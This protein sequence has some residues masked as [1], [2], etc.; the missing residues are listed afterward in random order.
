[1]TE[2]SFQ[3]S[4][5]GNAAPLP[6]TV[7][8]GGLTA[9]WRRM[10]GGLPRPFW[11][12]FGG[13]LVNR[14]GYVVEP[15]LAIYLV[16]GRELPMTTVGY[17]VAAFGLGS[18][19]S[20]PISGYLADRVGRR[21]TIIGGLVGSAA[22]FLVL[23]AARDLGT[24]AVAAVCAGLMIDLYR[25]A[26]SALVADLVSP[27]DRPR[28]FGLLYWATNLG[29]SVA[30]VL[31][32]ALAERSYWLLFLL[33]A[34]TCVAFAVLILRYVPETRPRR[35]PG[36]AYGYAEVLH[37]PLL[38]GLAVVTLVGAVVYMQSFITLPLA[39]SADGL[40]PG[41]YGV[42]YAVNPI[43]VIV[44]QPLI[45]GRLTRFPQVFVYATAALVMGTGFGLTAFARSVPAYAATVLI[46]TLGEIAFNVA[47]PSIVADIAPERLR[48]RYHG[49]VGLA[50]GGSAF[51]APLLGT[52][53]LDEYG[54]GVLWGGCF[55]ASAACAAGILVLGPAL[56]QRRLGGRFDVRRAR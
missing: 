7:P 28:A 14:L 41:A 19:V 56:K 8:S 15:F 26:V 33:D 21:A 53:L 17:L 51:I 4:L 13:T 50:F 1:V 36:V 25:P 2:Q 35:A 5:P 32:G 42:V 3:S 38:I 43:A 37:D 39:M 22:T 16:R 24:L 9:W 46:W 30:G 55:V 20:Q 48:G 31:G 34:L 27:A 23:G 44:V 47:G 6:P 18:S 54:R 12:L 29:V 52:R 40:G 10:G 49:V 11:V 45:L